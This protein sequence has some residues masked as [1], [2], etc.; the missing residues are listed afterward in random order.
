MNSIGD[1][2]PDLIKLLYS[3][4]LNEMQLRIIAQPELF[5]DSS[6]VRMFHH[7]SKPEDYQRAKSNFRRFVRERIF[8]SRVA[9]MT[10]I[11]PSAPSHSFD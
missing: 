8:V 11:V 10:S 9:S 6:L 2:G 4:N 5:L 1:H 7:H 3:G